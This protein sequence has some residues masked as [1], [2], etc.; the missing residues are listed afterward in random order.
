MCVAAAPAV[1][2]TQPLQSMLMH[3]SSCSDTTFLLPAAAY[4][5]ALDRQRH[6][7]NR[8]NRQGAWA[9]DSRRAAP[10]AAL[11]R[12]LHAGAAGVR[13]RW[14]DPCRALAA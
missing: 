8:R 12:C 6:A 5:L 4:T 13:L 14:H 7:D 10:H 9:V 3:A 11:A 1:G 2:L